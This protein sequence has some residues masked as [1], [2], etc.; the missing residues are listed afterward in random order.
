MPQVYSVCT[1]SLLI[2]RA[3]KLNGLVRR[4]NPSVVTLLYCPFLSGE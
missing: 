3:P 1:V 2:D 4:A